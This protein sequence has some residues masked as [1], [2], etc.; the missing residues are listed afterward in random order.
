MVIAE[1]N[2]Y[3]KGSTGKI[4]LQIAKC[5]REQGINIDT[6]STNTFTYKYQKLPL[7]PQGHHYF[8][9]YFENAIHYIWGR[10]IGYNGCFS[11]FSTQR[12]IAKL[13]KHH[14]DILHLHNLHG[15]CINFPSLFRYIKK[16]NINVIWTLHDCWAFTGHCPH[17]DMIGCDKWKTQCNKCP[18]YG[19]YP[20]SCF[21][22][23]KHMHKL[24][25]KWFTSVE[26]M[27]LVTPSQW[28]A[29]LVKKSFLKNYPVE[30][31]NNGIDLEVFKP[32][33]NDFRKKY[34]C[35][36]KILL[37]G[38]ASNWNVRKGLDVFIELANR[39]DNKF[40]IVLVGTDENVD[41]QLSENIISIHRTQNQVEL[42]QIYTAADLFINPTREENYPTVNMEALACGTPVLTFNTGGSPEIIDCTCGSVVKKNDIDGMEKEI[43]K[44]TEEKIFSKENCLERAKSFDMKYAFQ[45]YVN[46]YKTISK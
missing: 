44:I 1:V 41:K 24:K 4:M 2:M 16:E 40:Q 23:S 6:F 10:T 46:L 25:K 21:D 13:K 18:Q 19:A 12:L 28:L 20:A 37:L 17:F 36:D 15:Y 38:V 26:N 33:D 3:S 14:V 22:D 39:L 32:T 31:I 30:V 35:E 29:G 27:T 9:T 8:G 45:K 5:A 43:V 34:L 42:A 7:P 11:W